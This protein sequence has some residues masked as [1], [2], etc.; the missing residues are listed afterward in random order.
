MLLRWAFGLSKPGRLFLPW[1]HWILTSTLTSGE[2]RLSARSSC[3]SA[4]PYPTAAAPSRAQGHAR[5]TARELLGDEV[6]GARVAAH[7][8]LA[9]EEHEWRA[10]AGERTQARMEWKT[11]RPS[12]GIC[13]Q[14]VNWP[15]EIALSGPRPITSLL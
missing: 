5:A 9:D 1:V 11:E 15:S 13:A 6:V 3:W 8:D 4:G 7:E 10:P 2:E 14:Y 12:L